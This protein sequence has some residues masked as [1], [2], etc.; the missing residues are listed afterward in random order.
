M[1]NSHNK[2]IILIEN[3]RRSILLF[4]SQKVI[5]DTDL[6]NLYGV[7]TKVLNQAVKRNKK[8]FPSDFVFVLTKEEK[9]KV[10]TICDHL[11]QLKYSSNLPCVF[12]EHGA[13]MAAAV[14][15]SSRAIEMSLLI[16][17][18]FV[19]LRKILAG[20]A[21][22]ARRLDELEKKY[23]KRFSVVFQA[24]KELMEPK[25]KPGKKIIGFKI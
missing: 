20:S 12:T 25:V 2:N 22:L 18:T 24:I 21:D 17:R 4:R 6:A 7:T 16:I 13:L 15:N 5:I 8:R 23:D 11:K 14:L 3:V 9:N 19:Q 1:R 10:V